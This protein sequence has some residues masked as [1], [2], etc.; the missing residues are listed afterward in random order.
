MNDVADQGV[1]A[2]TS[3]LPYSFFYPPDPTGL[4]VFPLIFNPT[5]SAVDV[6]CEINKNKDT[7][8][9]RVYDV[10]VDVFIGLQWYTIKFGIGMPFDTD[11]NLP[12][13]YKFHDSHGKKHALVEGPGGGHLPFYQLFLKNP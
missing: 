5:W 4:G 12:N 9:F 7:W 11:R 6:E 1:P 8:T 13:P 2:I 10:A 3:D